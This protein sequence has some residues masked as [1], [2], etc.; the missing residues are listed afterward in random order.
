MGRPHFRF[1]DLEVWQDSCELAVLCHG[2]ADELTERKFYR[3]AEQL[4]GAGLSPSNNIAEGSASHHDRE[5]IQFLN[6][7]R[8]S[9]AEL[10]SMS[11]TFERMEILDEEP[12]S[13]IL[14][15][16]DKTARKLTALIK[17]LSR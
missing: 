12:T 15:L 10:A 8:R 4:R 9:A 6:I 17:H 11:L 1:E 13:Q 3:Y 16:A 7:A 5:F 14:E 2:I